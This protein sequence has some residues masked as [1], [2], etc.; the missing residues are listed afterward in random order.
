MAALLTQR[1]VERVT[2]VALATMV[3]RANAMTPYG[4][5]T[6]AQI[7]ATVA[8]DP[9]GDTAH[10]L[11]QLIAWGVEYLVMFKR[12]PDLLEVFGTEAR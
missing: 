3:R 7:A 5:V 8:A 12:H 2:D 10:Y 11:A 9:L 4:E 6:A 1:Q